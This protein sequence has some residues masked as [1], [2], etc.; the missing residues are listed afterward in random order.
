M[1]D[2]METLLRER[3]EWKDAAEWA[4]KQMHEYKAQCEAL[5]VERDWWKR[6]NTESAAQAHRYAQLW[7]SASRGLA[8]AI[9]V[10]P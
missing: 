5:R 10:K 3:D 6:Q 4:A 8:E 1:P 2:A 9:G 7:E